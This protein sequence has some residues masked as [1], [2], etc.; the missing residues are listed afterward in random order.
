MK[1]DQPWLER[2][3]HRLYN[4]CLPEPASAVL[5]K[6]G[7][8]GSLFCPPLLSAQPLSGE[9][10]AGV[11]NCWIIK[12]ISHNA[13]WQATLFA[14]EKPAVA[15]HR[16]PFSGSVQERPCTQTCRHRRRRKGIRVLQRQLQVEG[17]RCEW[18]SELSEIFFSI[19]C[20]RLSGSSFES[21]D[22]SVVRSPV[23]CFLPP[24]YTGSTMASNTFRC[25][26]KH[27]LGGQW[28]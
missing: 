16:T 11:L 19:P 21:R 12:A 13:T 26:Q 6:N 10:R 14:E 9:R 5:Y 8:T 1:S 27:L 15:F 25:L 7:C 18:R 4:R 3:S 17:L 20:Y 22:F 28:S 2:S 23:T 24:G